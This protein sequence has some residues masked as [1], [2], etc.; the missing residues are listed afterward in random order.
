VQKIKIKLKR[1][2]KKKIQIFSVELQASMKTLKDLITQIVSFEVQRFNEKQDNPSIISFLTPKELD[3]KSQSGK[4]SFGDI[5]KREKVVEDTSIE[6]ALLGFKDGLF[7]VFIDDQEIKNVED[8]IDLTTQSEVVFMRL[9][10][11][12]GTYW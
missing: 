7:V 6:N 10:F 3:E 8:A 12:T 1:L 4:V 11:L 9:T 2:G 5:Y